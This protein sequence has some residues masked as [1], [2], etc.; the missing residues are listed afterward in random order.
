[1]RVSLC[2]CAFF[3]LLPACPAIRCPRQGHS[4]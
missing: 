1:M 3:S 2:F 4:C